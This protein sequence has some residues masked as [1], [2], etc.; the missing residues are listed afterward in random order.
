MLD[1]PQGCQSAAD[2]RR[3]YIAV[4][5]RIKARA[6]REEP[7]ALAK[8]Q[9]AQHRGYSILYPA[10]IGPTRPT[11]FPDE[12]VGKMVYGFPIG[13]RDVLSLASRPPR[14]KMAREIIQN[15]ARKHG[16]SIEAILSHRRQK[17]IVAARHEAIYLISEETDMSLPQIGRI[18]GDR[19]HTT[20]LHA[21]RKWRAT[22]PE[23]LADEGVDYGRAV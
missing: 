1:I 19:D 15:M 13:P 9:R 6:I 22:H 4:R 7:D 18:M 3:H 11:F 21:I 17:H 10:P 16:L 12:K 20:I 8:V 2:F 14:K 5:R 23:P